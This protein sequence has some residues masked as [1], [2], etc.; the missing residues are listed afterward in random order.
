MRPGWE[1]VGG[2][3]PAPWS[4]QAIAVAVI[5]TSVV[6]VGG[7]EPAFARK[8]ASDWRADGGALHRSR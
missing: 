4:L 6:R 5:R 3:M 2:G 7:S 1:R 8:L